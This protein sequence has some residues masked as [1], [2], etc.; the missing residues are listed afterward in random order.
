[1][2]NLLGRTQSNFDSASHAALQPGRK[3]VR[4]LMPEDR[5]GLKY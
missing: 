1:M 4:A 3:V 2:A 5:A